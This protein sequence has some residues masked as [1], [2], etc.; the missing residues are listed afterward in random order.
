MTGDGAGDRRRWARVDVHL[1][2]QV[3]RRAETIHTTVASDL[4]VGGMFIHE[5]LPYDNGSLLHLSFR[6]VGVDRWVECDAR[7]THARTEFREGFPDAPIGNGLEFVELGEDD[8]EAI[9]TFVQ[10]R[11]T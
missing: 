6:V 5:L 7:V 9:A 10:D 4:S 2:V 8:R 3:A 1:S 11:G